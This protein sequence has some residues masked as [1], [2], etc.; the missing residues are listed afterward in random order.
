MKLVA[1]ALVATL[2]ATTRSTRSA[3]AQGAAPAPLPVPPPPPTDGSPPIEDEAPAPIEEVAQPPPPPP[4]PQCDAEAVEADH[5]ALARERRSA[6]TWNTAW[7]ISYVVFA[8]GQVGLAL[9]EFSPGRE[10]D[11]AQE[12]SLYIGAGKAVIGSLARL[13]L[14]LRVPEVARS[15]DPCVDQA[16]L[17]RVHAYTARKE[18]RTFW[19]QLGG[20]LALHAIGGS[21]LVLKEDSWRDA[22]TSFALGAVVSTLT[23]YTQPKASWRRGPRRSVSVVAVPRLDGAGIAVVGAF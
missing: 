3:H 7:M 9:A 12:S 22:L 19:L 2:T 20:G 18:K 4:P 14:P 5:R 6:R 10:F 23:L 8:G 13:V 16:A 21:Y 17:D 1:I 11:R 15:G